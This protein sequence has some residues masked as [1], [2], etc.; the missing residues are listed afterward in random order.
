MGNLDVE[1]SLHGCVEFE[2]K[3]RAKYISYQG[4]FRGRTLRSGWLD[5]EVLGVQHC[6][7]SEVFAPEDL[8]SPRNIGEANRKRSSE[9]SRRRPEI[10]Q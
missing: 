7:S 1:C 4:D 5:L 6:M 8:R 3:L 10:L 9:T 2:L